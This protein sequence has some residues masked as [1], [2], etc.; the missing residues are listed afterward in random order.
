MV[1]AYT[2]TEV[3]EEGAMDL[4]R[5]YRRC[6]TP[7][8]SEYLRVAA[9]A[10]ASPSISRWRYR[11]STKLVPG[12]HGEPLPV[13]E[14]QQSDCRLRSGGDRAAYCKIIVGLDWGAGKAAG[15]LGQGR[16]ASVRAS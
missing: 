1:S 2:G 10:A 3:E 12:S 9:E 4:Q 14:G 16:H 7:V 11:K 8:S 13:F 5:G 6:H 15:W